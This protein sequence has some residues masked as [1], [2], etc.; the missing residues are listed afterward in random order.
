MRQREQI[1][2]LNPNFEADLFDQNYYL[3]LDHL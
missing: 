1:K 2:A 3:N